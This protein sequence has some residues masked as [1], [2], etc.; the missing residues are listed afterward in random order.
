MVGVL[1]R[2]DKLMHDACWV[3]VYPGLSEEMLDFVAGRIEAFFG[4]H[5]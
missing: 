3:G 5:E 2:T 4:L 1:R